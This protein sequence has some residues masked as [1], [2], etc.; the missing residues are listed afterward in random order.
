MRKHVLSVLAY[1]VATFVTQAVSH[2][3]VNADHYASL[4]YLRENPIFALGILS[5]LIQGGVLAYLYSHTN[6]PG[7]SVGDAVRFAWVA[8]SILVSYIALAEAAKYQV[9]AIAPWIT[10]ETAAGFVQFT[11]YGVLL[12]LVHRQRLPALVSSPA[13][14]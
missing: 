6:S 11:V 12:G 7:R 14:S 8:G 13:G 5:M 3:V 10:V 4:P 9:P 1:V 2:F